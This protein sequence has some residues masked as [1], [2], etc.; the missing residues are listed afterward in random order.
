VTKARNAALAAL[1][2]A[3]EPVS[4]AGLHKRLGS[5]CDQATVYRA[6]HFLEERGLA[7]SF[8][9]HCQEHGTERYFVSRNA[10]HRHWFHCGVC[11]RFLDLGAC[12][13][14]PM[15]GEMERERGLKIEG[16]V[17]YFTGT[18]PAC[19]AALH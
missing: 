10:G 6:L 7:E 12:P 1:D 17:M 15:L 2:S 8:V 5:C 13:I 19:A 14:G 16:H 3:P 4:A 9:L 11:H 18:C